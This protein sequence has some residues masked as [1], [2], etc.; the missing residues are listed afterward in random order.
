VY[1]YKPNGKLLA[2]TSSIADG[3]YSIANLPP[4]ADG[5]IV[6]FDGRAAAPG[7]ASYLPRCWEDQ[8][9]DGLA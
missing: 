5:Y 9:W 7:T 8:A 6:C 2:V 1:V 4:S 3:T